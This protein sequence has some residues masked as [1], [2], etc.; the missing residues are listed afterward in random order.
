V[1]IT[2]DG[3]LLGHTW[4]YVYTY[5]G[6]LRAKCQGGGLVRRLSSLVL[7]FRPANGRAKHAEKGHIRFNPG[8][9]K[10][11]ALLGATNGGALPN[12]GLQ[13]SSGTNPRQ[14]IEKHHSLSPALSGVS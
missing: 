13:A 8:P 4:V 2:F 10:Q 9:Q 14:P 1:F 11:S 6:A 12:A 3:A 5:L 7:V